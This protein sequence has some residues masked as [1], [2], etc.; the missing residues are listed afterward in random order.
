MKSILTLV[1]A[2]TLGLAGAALADVSKKIGRAS[3]IRAGKSSVMPPR[4]PSGPMVDSSFGLRIFA[5]RAAG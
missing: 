2:L 1:T 5:R 4:Q 3:Q